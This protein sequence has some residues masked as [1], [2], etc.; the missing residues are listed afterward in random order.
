[1]LSEFVPL[2]VILNVRWSK[3]MPIDHSP[4]ANAGIDPWQS[5]ELVGFP[6]ILSPEKDMRKP[7]TRRFRTSNEFE[8]SLAPI[9]HATD[10]R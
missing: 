8:L 5:H 6:K 10:Q 3:P 2:E 9:Q 4:R 1:M 7:R